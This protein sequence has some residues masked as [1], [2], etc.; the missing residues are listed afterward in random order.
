LSALE[1]VGV[2][3]VEVQRL[4]RALRRHGARLTGRVFTPAERRYAQRWRAPA[5]PLAARLAA[6]L[7]LRAALRMA[8]R[9]C[10]ALGQ[11]EVV[12][13][14]GGRPALRWNGD[15][16]GG[17]VHLSLTHEARWALASVWLEEP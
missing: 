12:R 14:P 3:L 4:E 16:E 6:K 1:G 11:V 13:A 15:G 8:R 10:P 9:R 5:Q 7:A 2:G 17:G